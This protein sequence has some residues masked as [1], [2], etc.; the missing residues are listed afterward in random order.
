MPTELNDGYCQSNFHAGIQR[1]GGFASASRR[2]CPQPA[3]HA[4]EIG[5]ELNPRNAS[6]V[7]R[8]HP[9]R[10]SPAQS[11]LVSAKAMNSGLSRD[12]LPL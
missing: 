6:E 3:L 10:N 8:G 9:S 1:K 7:K 11:T 2:C 12:S 4:Y 5:R